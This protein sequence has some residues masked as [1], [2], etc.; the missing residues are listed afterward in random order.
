MQTLA[1]DNDY[2]K[3][4]QKIIREANK[5]AEDED[6]DKRY[7]LALTPVKFGISFTVQHLNQAGALVHIYTDVTRFRSIMVVR[8]WVKGCM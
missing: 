7:G 3:R 6:S 2:D 5:K 1:D 8:R 4:R